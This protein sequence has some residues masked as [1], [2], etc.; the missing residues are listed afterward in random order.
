MWENGSCVYPLL[1]RRL[2]AWPFSSRNTGILNKSKDFFL[3]EEEE[4]YWEETVPTTPWVL[5]PSN[6]LC[7]S[8]H[9]CKMT[10][11]NDMFSNSF[12]FLLPGSPV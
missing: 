5:S 11:S 1:E 2:E 6:F 9:F 8:F 3:E 4:T 7:F 10:D 12:L